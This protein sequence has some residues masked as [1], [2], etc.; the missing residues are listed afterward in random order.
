MRTTLGAAYAWLCIRFWE[1]RLRHA[2]QF[3]LDLNRVMDSERRRADGDIA[4]CETMVGRARADAVRV[5][6]DGRLQGQRG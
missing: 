6:A 4:H 5:R 3:R 1:R 2:Q